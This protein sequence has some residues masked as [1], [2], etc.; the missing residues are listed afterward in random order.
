M[1]KVVRIIARL[2]VGGPARHCLLLDEGL[3]RR[4]FE[5]RLLSGALAPGESLLPEARR[6]RVEQVPGLGRGLALGG[7]LRA[8]LS[9]TRFLRRERPQ[10]V[11]THTA[12]AGVLGRVAARLAGVPVVVHSFHGHVLA[13]YFG[14]TGSRLATCA[15]RGLA[16]LTSQLV[17]LSPRLVTELAEEFAV[18]PRERFE[19]VP[20]GRDLSSF[21]APPRGLLRAELGLGP[22]TPLVGCVGRL[23]PIKDVPLLLRAMEQ[24]EPSAH[25]VVVGDGPERGR[26]EAAIPPALRGRVHLLGWRAD[27]PAIYGDLDLFALSSRNEGTPLAIVEALAAGVP[28]VATAVGGIPDM[29]GNELGPGR[30]EAGRLVSSGDAAGLG[31]AIQGLLRDEVGRTRASLAARRCAEVYR[32][33]HLVERMAGLYES[34]LARAA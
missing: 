10:I 5:T 1:P 15:E 19:V 13:G 27:L 32:A 7:D 29:L 33:E 18:A 20:L 4:G 28:I 9:L 3:R 25:L 22:E 30:F 2:N 14:P 24:V 11:H 12:K 23:V 8:L 16:H 6:A 31:V 17:T 26:I 34:L 21:A